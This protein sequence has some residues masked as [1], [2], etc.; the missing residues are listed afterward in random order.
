MTFDPHSTVVR[1]VYLDTNAARKAGYLLSSSWVQSLCTQAR[2]LSIGLYLPQLVADEWFYDLRQKGLA[3]LSQIHSGKEQLARWTGKEVV[4]LKCMS[5]NTL[6]EALRTGHGERLATAGFQIFPNANPDLQSLIERAV[7]KVPPF[8]TGDKGFRDAIILESI[9]RHIREKHGKD[10]VLVVSE[11]RAFRNGIGAVVNQGFRVQACG[12]EEV[13]RLIEESL[14]EAVKQLRTHEAAIALKFLNEHKD[15]IFEHV[16]RCQISERS[17]KFGRG[18]HDPL[19]D[20]TIKRVNAVRPEEIKGALPK[21]GFLSAPPGTTDIPIL[22]SV[23]VNLDL[24]ISQFNLARVFSWRSIPLTGPTELPDKPIGDPDVP[25][26]VESDISIEHLISL[27]AVATR[28]DDPDHPLDE[29]RIVE[30]WTTAGDTE[31]P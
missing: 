29:L 31:T 27:R 9:A 30:D 3:A 21:S 1:G 8:E 14:D 24:T 17:L 19:K 2:D 10:R 23:S 26:N 25:F 20:A 13:N 4:T 16:Y 11:D 22:L 5:E 28:T 12:V 6:I 7:N 15:M 18:D